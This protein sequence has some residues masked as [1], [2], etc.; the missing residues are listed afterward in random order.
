MYNHDVCQLSEFLVNVAVVDY[1][2]TVIVY[3]VILEVVNVTLQDLRNYLFGNYRLK[4]AVNNVIY[5]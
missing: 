2:G 3:Q 5:K 4:I 1:K